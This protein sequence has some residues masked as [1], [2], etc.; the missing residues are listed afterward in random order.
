MQE[1]TVK[2]RSVFHHYVE[3][4]D[5]KQELCWSFG[6]KKKNI[7][8]GLFRILSANALVPLKSLKIQTTGNQ[9]GRPHSPTVS[10]QQKYSAEVES[11]LNALSPEG[12]HSVSMTSLSRASSNGSIHGSKITVEP[13]N[14]EQIIPIAHYESGKNT[15][16]GSYYVTHPGTYVLVFDNSFS[17]KTPKK[18]FFFVGLRDVE[19]KLSIHRKDYEGWLLK[20][21]NRS[22]QGFSRRWIEV[23]SSGV[24]SYFKSPGRTS[25]GSMNLYSS[26]IRLN[27][28]Y[29][30]IDIDTENVT[31][32]FKAES[33]E[34]F[35]KWTA[36]FERYSSGSSLFERNSFNSDSNLLRNGSQT[37]RDLVSK[38]HSELIT[39]RTMINSTFSG[40]RKIS[41]KDVKHPMNSMAEIERILNIAIEK[42]NE[43]LIS[44]KSE[45]D[46]SEAFK[47]C[48]AD[49]N[50]IRSKF[51]LA[52]VTAESFSSGLLATSPSI[53]DEEE[54]FFDAEDGSFFSTSEDSYGGNAIENSDS[55]SVTSVVDTVPVD[56]ASPSLSVAGVLRRTELPVPAQ[57]MEN[58]SIMGILRNNVGKDLSTVAMPIALN[59][60]INLL[61]K[62]CEELEYCSLLDEASNIVDPVNRLA[63]V[64]AFVVS[65]YSST[66]HRAARKPFNPL[67]GE[68]FE[69]HR[70]DKGFNYISEKVSHHPPIIACH[71]ESSNYTF[72]QDSLLKTKFWG[73]SME[74][75][76]I[77]TAHI[78]FKKLNEHYV[79]NK[80]TTSMR[81]IFS[82]GR[83]LEH[84]GTLKISSKTTGHY[85]EL[86]FKE[87]GYFAS[88]GNEVVGGIYNEVGKKVLCIRFLI[89]NIAVGGIVVS[90][91]MTKVI[92]MNCRFYGAWALFL[93]ISWKITVLLLLLLK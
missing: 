66:V 62:M 50:R 40:E 68:T 18:L 23:H 45:I 35:E 52:Q 90:T 15:V 39:C 21:G 75:S 2:P 61:Q 27:H 88:S 48:L 19:Q 69:F 33:Q 80:V 9:K 83:Y 58:I 76:S 44:G 64:A 42:A 84:H 79:Y 36:V 32:H 38:L 71:A 51:G 53:R 34:Q 49:N 63:V 11:Q 6:T 46:Q 26:A 28:D 78:I 85:C 82:S 89:F 20:K 29:Y 25:H 47:A 4:K 24:L 70:P 31:Y 8:F 14:S 87:S 81:N 41:R 74:L 60:P 77:G 59:E 57:P 86:N 3:I 67:L 17:V 13:L 10:V 1:I 55:E 92:P 65:A 73:K 16:K 91:S 56:L 22:M 93:L 5:K 54:K 30:V 12:R 43:L 37:D 72:Y 7:S